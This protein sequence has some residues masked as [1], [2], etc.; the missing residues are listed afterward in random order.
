MSADHVAQS[1]SPEI[2]AIEES[3][4]E[5]AHIA[6]RARQHERLMAVAALALDRAAAATLRQLAD[7]E[8]AR[9]GELAARL[10][11]EASHVTRQVQLLE[12]AG[13]V[14]RTVDPE[15]GRAQ[16]VQLTGL[17]RGAVQRIR[18]ASRHG[19]Q[20]ALADWSAEDVK[21]LAVLFRRMVDDFVAHA[22]DELG[23]RF[24]G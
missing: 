10:A 19:V 1:V 18:T 2:I 22:E 8:P 6:T 11:V 7:C 16:L 20:L 17:G 23:Y 4:T 24:P 13:Y 21:G 9:I 5:L 3:L 14:A 12:K 15:D